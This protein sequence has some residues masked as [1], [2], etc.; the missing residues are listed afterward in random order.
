M[1]DISSSI[2]QPSGNAAVFSA[3]NE[4]LSIDAGVTVLAENSTFS[5]YSNGQNNTNLANSGG[6]Y[7]ATTGISFAVALINGDS[8]VNNSSIG[9][10]SGMGAGLG[11]GAMAMM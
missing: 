6:I 5:V 8:S 2:F 4:L 11:E 7:N 1:A 9:V 10:I 3:P